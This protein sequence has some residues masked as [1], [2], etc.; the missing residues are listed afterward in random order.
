MMYT[1]EG[2]LTKYYWEGNLCLSLTKS[3]PVSKHLVQ[4]W[5]HISTFGFKSRPPFPFR[6]NLDQFS[7]TVSFFKSGPHPLRFSQICPPPPLPQVIFSDWLL[8]ASYVHFPRFF[9]TNRISVQSVIMVGWTTTLILYLLD[10][11]W[12]SSYNNFKILYVTLIQTPYT[13][14]L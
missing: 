1:T 13:R 5:T 6:I 12:K 10:N 14:T 7:H 4:I 8:K 11:C 9:L 3:G 2:P